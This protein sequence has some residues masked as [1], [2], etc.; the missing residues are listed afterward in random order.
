VP[1]LLLEEP[2][3]DQAIALLLVYLG[4]STCDN[5]ERNTRIA[6]GQMEMVAQPEESQSIKP[7]FLCRLAE[8]EESVR[9]H[10]FPSV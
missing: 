7:E 8:I 4:A 2:A 1:C 6:G 10:D 9:Y 5:R 3:Q